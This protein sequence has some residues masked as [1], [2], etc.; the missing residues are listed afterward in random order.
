MS[1]ASD[2]RD[3][4][5]FQSVNWSD[6]GNSGSPTFPCQSLKVPR[7]AVGFSSTA[8]PEKHRSGEEGDHQPELVIGQDGPREA[9]CH[10]EHA[11]SVTHL[12]KV[13]AIEDPVGQESHPRLRP[14]SPSLSSMRR[15]QPGDADNY[16][17]N[18]VSAA[19]FSVTGSA[20][21]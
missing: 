15:D 2:Q 21:R 12:I 14:P 20:W 11:E 6:S 7:S 1:T 9:S 19:V 5:P 8:P 10:Q 4:A 18:T 17:C 13:R 3:L 16:C